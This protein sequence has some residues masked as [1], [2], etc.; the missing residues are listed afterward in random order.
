MPISPQELETR[1]LLRDTDFNVQL[2]DQLNNQIHQAQQQILC[3]VRNARVS[4][5][6]RYLQDQT[7]PGL[8]LTCLKL[9]LDYSPGLQSGRL[10]EHSNARRDHL[11]NA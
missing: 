2:I 8:Q 9:W 3:V 11:R 1:A 5:I 10:I 4:N 7:W 6:L